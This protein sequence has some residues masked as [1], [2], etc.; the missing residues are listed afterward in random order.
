MTV[1]ERTLLGR[2]AALLI[3]VGVIAALWLGPVAAYRGLL[4]EDARA[5]Q[6]GEQKLLR[7]RALAG[8]PAGSPREIDD[9]AVLFPR[10]SDAQELALLQESLKSAAAASAVEIQGL[11]VLQPE[12]LP[13]AIRLGVRLKGRGDIAG[14]DRLLYAVEAARPLLYPD[15]LQIQSRASQPSAA[16]PPLDFQ[17]DVSGFKPAPPT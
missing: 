17:L 8:A 3:L 16:P 11:Q 2:A 15:N 14:L 12:T 1:A 13:G 10:D 7:Y 6:A 4:D 5:L 9:K